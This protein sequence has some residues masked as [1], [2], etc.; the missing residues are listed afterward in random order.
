MIYNY[1]VKSILVSIIEAIDNFNFLLKNHHKHT[2][3]IAYQLGCAYG[4]DTDKLNNLVLAASIHDIGALYVDERDQLLYIDE[5]NPKPHEI[6]GA[7]MLEDFKPL[8]DIKEIIRHHHIKYSE[9]IENTIKKEDVRIECYFLHLADRIDILL[10]TYGKDSYSRTL[11]IDE[12]N[13]RFGDIFLPDLK[14]VFNQLAQDNEFWENIYDLA[15]HELL[16]LNI[17]S[18]NFKMDNSDIEGLSKIFARIVDFKSS[19]TKVHSITVGAFANEIGKYLNLNEKSCF[20]LKIA[21]YLHDIGKIAIPSEL[22]DKTDKLTDEEFQTIKSHAKYSS[23]ILKSISGLGNISKWAIHHHE[24]RDKSGYPLKIS[25]QKFSIEMDILAFSDILSAL[26]ENRPYRKTLPKNT[27]LQILKNLT[28][29]KL[30]FKV[31]TVIEANFDDLN[32]LY[33]KTIKDNEKNFIQ[34]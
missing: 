34:T 7:K 3:T 6:M 8:K 5:Q 9:I 14:Y 4:L 29:N 19:W 31:Y 13:I 17:D 23:M 26:L 22:L 32:N 11:I 27:I 30:D 20:E 28:P 12:I 25:D 15:F 10:E 18:D 1:D 2:A 16:L 24:K 21:G 33:Y